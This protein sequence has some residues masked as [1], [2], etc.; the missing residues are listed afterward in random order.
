MRSA[1]R[2]EA[3]LDHLENN[4]WI[5]EG[6]ELD[7]S[8]S[9]KRTV[10][11]AVVFAGACRDAQTALVYLGR[12]GV[13]IDDLW[14]GTELVTRAQNAHPVAEIKYKTSAS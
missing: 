4:G 10:E 6:M 3:S 7:M 2:L 11:V 13:Q 5:N 9:T 8:T 14:Q 1:W 12:V